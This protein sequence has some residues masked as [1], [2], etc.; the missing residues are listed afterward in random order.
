[1]AEPATGELSAH[2]DMCSSSAPCSKMTGPLQSVHAISL[3][4][5]LAQHGILWWSCISPSTYPQ[6]VEAAGQYSAVLQYPLHPRSLQELQRLE[7]TSS[8]AGACAPMLRSCTAVLSALRQDAIQDAALAH[9]AEAAQPS[10]VQTSFLRHGNTAV[11]NPQIVA[12]LESWHVSLCKTPHVIGDRPTRGVSTPLPQP[13]M[14]W[15]IC[16]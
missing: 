11:R 12:A 15:A 14:H 7:L 6:G 16:G 10:I 1:M 8:W 4:S 9:A 13:L 5:M 3:S 2:G